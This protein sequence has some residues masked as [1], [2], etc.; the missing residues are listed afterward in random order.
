MSL[1]GV[2]LRHRTLALLL[3]AVVAAVA[4]WVLLVTVDPEGGGDRAAVD[5]TVTAQPV[6]PVVTGPPGLSIEWDGVRRLTG[7]P[8][9]RDEAFATL[10]R[11]LGAAAGARPEIR[12][13]GNSTDQ[14]WWNPTGDRRPSTILFD[15]TPATLDDLAWL[16]R[17]T[18]AR[19]TLGVN[20]ALGDEARDVAFVTA[21]R[22]R[23]PRG[24]LQ[25]LEVGN[26]PDLYAS[27]RT[28]RVGALVLHRVRKRATYGPLRYA[29]ELRTTLTALHDGVHPTPPLIVGGLAGEAWLSAL[30][31]ILDVVAPL[32]TGVS[33][34]LYALRTCE[35]RSAPGALIDRLLDPATTE[36]LVARLR[37]TIAAARPHR[38][39]VPVTELDSAVC[40]GVAGVSDT[41]AA[42]LWLD[43]TLLAVRAAG[44]SAA[45]VHTFPGAFYSVVGPRRTGQTA[46]RPPYAGMLLAAQ[47]APRGSRMLVTRAVGA[48]GDLRVHAARTAD[49]G[50]GVM[51]VNLAHAGRRT[52][53]LRLAAAARDGCATVQR[54]DGPAL[55]SEHGIRVHSGSRSCPRSG[56]HV[57]RFDG[58]G[59][60][61]LRLPAPSR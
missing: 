24:A 39:S 5:V 10:V 28:F 57:L 23:L 36:A 3:L 33:D 6:G 37:R 19:L 50:L 42:A 15:I 59:A 7:R 55:A 61:L 18:G 27:A 54:L 9:D 31:A 48:G 47:T 40:G 1:P 26:E 41:L 51:V 58:P 25:A 21:A 13:G 8:G 2:S 20:L 11:R 52:V 44:A 12:V 38:L 53:R 56:L 34:H 32:P 30:P 46:P 4:V 14:S 49:G 29:A 17:R 35:D 16:A 45:D 22:R 43:D 60:A